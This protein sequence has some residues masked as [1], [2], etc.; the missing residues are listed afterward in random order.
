MIHV[1][2]CIS[3]G[4]VGWVVYIGCKIS[5]KE[6]NI[7]QLQNNFISKNVFDWTIYSGIV[8]KKYLQT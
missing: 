6:K 4:F 2:V 5:E 8:I 7:N 3:H 1:T